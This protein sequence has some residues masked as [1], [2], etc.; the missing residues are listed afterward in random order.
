M[1]EVYLLLKAINV[2]VMILNILKKIEYEL[3]FDDFI[4]A[5]ELFAKALGNL[6]NY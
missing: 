2:S 1:V 5:D 6:K 4:L 3:S